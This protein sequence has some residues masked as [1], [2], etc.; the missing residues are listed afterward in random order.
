MGFTI[1]FI[2]YGIDRSKASINI[3]NFRFVVA[4]DNEGNFVT[5]INNDFNFDWEIL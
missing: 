2:A 3:T 1:E 5:D 4:S